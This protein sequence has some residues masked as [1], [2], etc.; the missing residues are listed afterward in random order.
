M[1]E[2]FLPVAKVADVQP[3]AAKTVVID[4]REIAI[5]NVDGTFYALDNSCPHSGG[6]LAEGWIDKE[7]VT[8]PWHAWCFRLADGKM[9][10]GYGSVD[11]YDVKVEGEELLLNP[12]PRAPEAQP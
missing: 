12:V 2:S 5:F 6:S 10:L 9:T 7:T 3:G 8:C 1:T 11:A 4:G